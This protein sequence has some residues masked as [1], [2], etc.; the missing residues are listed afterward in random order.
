MRALEV[1][2]GDISILTLSPTTNRMNRLRIFPEMCARTSW[3]L[4]S[5]T[6]NMVPARTAEMVPSTSTALSS[7]SAP[8]MGPLWSVRRL[9]RPPPPLRL[10]GGPAITRSWVGCE[11]KAAPT[12]T[13]ILD[14]PGPAIEISLPDPDFPAPSPPDAGVSPG[15]LALT[16]AGLAPSF[17]ALSALGQT[18]RNASNED[19]FC[20]SCRCRTQVA[21]H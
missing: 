5:L 16:L 10:L 18:P 7:P 15:G 1:S 17:P 21:R 9:R 13:I 6:L 14:I 8:F 12:Q 4:G 2:Y 19:L 11:R 20:Q 3:S